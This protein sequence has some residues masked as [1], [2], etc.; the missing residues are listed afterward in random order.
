[1]REHLHNHEI[2]APIV[3]LIQ[4]LKIL[5]AQPRPTNKDATE[6]EV[7]DSL[8]FY[9]ILI[10]KPLS[11]RHAE[12]LKAMFIL[13]VQEAN[14]RGMKVGPSC[15]Y[16]SGCIT[17]ATKF[18]DWMTGSGY[19]YPSW[20]TTMSVAVA[21]DT[22]IRNIKLTEP[23]FLNNTAGIN[24]GNVTGLSFFDRNAERLKQIKSLISDIQS[25]LL[26]VDNYSPDDATLVVMTI[27]YMDQAA[28]TVQRSLDVLKP[29]IT[30]RE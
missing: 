1:M 20:L 26:T 25:D 23:E 18:M 22:L 9:L 15:K 29:K 12:K 28:H 27:A 6:I 7:L 21:F 30:I 19:P 24:A 10:D 16:G 17:V 2:V 14:S 4:F 8:G 5:I 11:N 13:A 3:R